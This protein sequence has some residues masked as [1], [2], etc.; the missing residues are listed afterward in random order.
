MIDTAISEKKPAQTKTSLVFN[1]YGLPVPHSK[2]HF[3]DS[4]LFRSVLIARSKHQQTAFAEQACIRR[5]FEV[6][7]ISADKPGVVS[8][9]PVVADVRSELPAVGAIESV[10]VTERGRHRHRLIFYNNLNQHHAEH[11]Q[12]A[13]DNHCNHQQHL[14]YAPVPVDDTLIQQVP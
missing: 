5:D 2:M 11:H 3:S 14:L 13:D 8:G 10:P 6:E 1:G 7:R 9:V 4:V 12:T